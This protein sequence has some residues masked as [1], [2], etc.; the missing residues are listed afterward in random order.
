MSDVSD[1]ETFAWGMVPDGTEFGTDAAPSDFTA[2]VGGVL[3]LTVT[4][5]RG[6]AR[7]EA[8]IV[9]AAPVVV[10][11]LPVV[12]WTVGAAITPLDLSG[13]VEGAR[14]VFA[15]SAYPGTTLNSST[16]EIIGTP[17]LEGMVSRVFTAQNSGGLVEIPLSGTVS[18]VAPALGAAVPAQSLVED[19]AMAPLNLNN[20]VTGSNLVFAVTSGPLPAGLGVSGGVISGTPTTVQPAQEVVF[21]VSNGGGFVDVPVQFVVDG[22]GVAPQIGQNMTMDDATGTWGLSSD[23]TGGMLHWAQLDSSAAIPSPNGSGGWTGSVLESGMVPYTGGPLEIDAGGT[24]GISYLLAVYHRNN[25]L[26]SNVLATT[27]TADKTAPRVTIPTLGAGNGTANVTVVTDEGDGTLFWRVNLASAA[28]P[29][30]AAVKAGTS[31]P[32]VASG[33]QALI[34]LSGLTNETEY[35]ISFLHRDSHRNES[36]VVSRVFTPT[37]GSSNSVTPIIGGFTI[38]DVASVPDVTPIA[39]AD[40]FLIEDI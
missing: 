37:T 7:A 27:Y 17:T 23:Q 39:I 38:N 2:A 9:E 19:A 29:D 26:D 20:H 14:L 31:R 33:S 13:V 35:R 16:G 11:T 18:P 1:I 25:T 30:A 5:A 21:T 4:T 6:L 8:A 15:G 40:G 22:A 36:I 10:G 3:Y 28:V 32:V 24:T 34:T 12:D